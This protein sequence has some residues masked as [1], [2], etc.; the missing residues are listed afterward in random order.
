MLKKNNFATRNQTYPMKTEPTLAS[1]R[2]E[3]W[4]S[5]NCL[6][7]MVY[8]LQSGVRWTDG[9]RDSVLLVIG[10]TLWVRNSRKYIVKYTEVH[11]KSV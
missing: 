4:L 9:R 3:L 2:Y 1:T 6:A 8:E 10:F 5:L 11:C 7:V